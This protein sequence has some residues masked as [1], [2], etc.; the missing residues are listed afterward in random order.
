MEL[1]PVG[2]L[3][4][5]QKADDDSAN[6]CKGGACIVPLIYKCAK[7]T[8]IVFDSNSVSK[9]CA[10]FYLGYSDW[11]RPGIENALSNKGLGNR[12][13]ERFI[14]SPEMA[15]LFLE[16]NIPKVKRTD[17]I[18]FKP[19]ELFQN[20]EIPEIVIFF[21][22]ADQ[23]SG[24]VFLINYSAPLENRITAPFAS[25]CGSLITIPLKYANEGINNA[26]WGL[27]DV[28]ARTRMP[29]DLMSIS[30]PYSLFVEMNSN[31]DESF[32]ISDNWHKLKNRN[33]E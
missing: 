17:S 21:A 24:I 20:N 22:N 23:I 8:T 4:S 5:D 12:Q 7:G 27:H 30:T 15:R 14:K 26:V 6:K 31:I 11:I 25:A 32:L 29:K 13:P 10:S 2:V 3:F 1:S 19:L 33:L 28:A 18:V 9:P 16:S